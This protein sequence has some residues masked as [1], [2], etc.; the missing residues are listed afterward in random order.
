MIFVLKTV[1]KKLRRFAS[2]IV[3]R[4]MNSGFYQVDASPSRGQSKVLHSSSFL[5]ARIRLKDWD[6]LGKIHQPFHTEL[7]KWRVKLPVDFSEN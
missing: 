6:L 1:V 2:F 7:A 4:S 3:A 5:R